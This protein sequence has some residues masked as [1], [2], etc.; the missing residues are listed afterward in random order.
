MI[1]RT[2]RH[3]SLI[4]ARMWHDSRWV[5]VTIRNISSH[6]LL[7][8]ADDPPPPGTQIEIRRGAHVIIGRTVW[9]HEGDFGVRTLD[10]L[11][12]PRILAS[13]DRPSA[14]AASAMSRTIER[15]SDPMRSHS[16]AMVRRYDASRQDSSTLQ[17]MFVVASGL[18]AAGFAAG[19]VYEMLAAP[20]S[21]V[22]TILAG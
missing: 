13:N 17:F 22:R 3:L 14:A 9:R 7:V 11:D 12:V 10:A 15:R 20:F 21:A 18:A 5:D 19:M 1:T 16:A 2:P 8:Y 4:G 6:G